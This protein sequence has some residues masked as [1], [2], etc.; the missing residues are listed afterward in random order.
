MKFRHFD[1]VISDD[2]EWVKL[3]AAINYYIDEMNIKGIDV[4]EV[5]A[6]KNKMIFNSQIIEKEVKSPF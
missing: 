4:S 3:L 5:I 6:V 2:F 1:T